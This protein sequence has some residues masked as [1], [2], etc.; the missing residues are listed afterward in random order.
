MK[1]DGMHGVETETIRRRKELV[2][3]MREVPQHRGLTTNEI[4]SVSG[5]YDRIRVGKSERCYKDLRFLHGK[6]L[7]Y[8]IPF[9]RSHARRVRWSA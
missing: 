4:V 9:D 1:D 6:L 5:V 7:V 8:R 3:W 2:T